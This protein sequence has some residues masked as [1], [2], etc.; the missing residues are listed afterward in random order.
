MEWQKVVDQRHQVQWASEFCNLY[1]RK[2]WLT[3]QSWRLA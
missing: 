2:W 1:E 3:Y